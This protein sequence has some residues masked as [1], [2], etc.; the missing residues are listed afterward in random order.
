MVQRFGWL[1]FALLA[2][3]SWGLWAFFP[4]LAMNYMKPKSV[5]IYEFIG[6]FIIGIIAFLFIGSKFEFNT[7]GVI[8]A[9]LT[10][11][12]GSL[13]A[14]FFLLALVK[15]RVSVVVVTT[16]LY[17]LIAILLAVL[18]LKEPIT[19]TQVFGMF[20]ALVAIILLSV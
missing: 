8:F 3:L 20:L 13:G 19:L 7:K 4:K 6:V 15:G 2:M 1:V 11:M 10:G 5:F 9:V 18:V 17:P 12:A 16:A 14:L